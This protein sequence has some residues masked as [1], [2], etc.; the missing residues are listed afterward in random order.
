[1]NHFDKFCSYSPLQIVSIC[2]TGEVTDLDDTDPM[3][4][5]A[6]S[7]HQLSANLNTTIEALFK[8]CFLNAK[9]APVM[10]IIRDILSLVHLFES[11]LRAHH[12]QLSE[13]N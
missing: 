2:G 3:I 4:G 6:S 5:E 12:W 9:A 7:L 13:V 1:M 10:K 8:R 11:Q